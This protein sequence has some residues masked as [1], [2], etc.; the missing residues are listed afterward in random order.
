MNREPTTIDIK[1]KITQIF[2]QISPAQKYSFVNKMNYLEDLDDLDDISMNS[3]KMKGGMEEGEIDEAAGVGIVPVRVVPRVP[4]PIADPEV[5]VV[6]EAEVPEANVESQSSQAFSEISLDEAELEEAIKLQKSNEI[7]RDEELKKFQ[8]EVVENFALPEAQVTYRD[9]EIITELIEYFKEEKSSQIFTNEEKLGLWVSDLMGLIKS[10]SVIEKDKTDETKEYIRGAKEIPDDYKPI[11]ES[12]EKGL[13]TSV[14]WITPLVREKRKIYGAGDL[15]NDYLYSVEADEEIKN[16]YKVIE[17][18]SNAGPQADRFVNYDNQQKILSELNKTSNITEDIQAEF[19]GKETVCIEKAEQDFKQKLETLEEETDE[20]FID[21]E[22]LKK[23]FGDQLEEVKSKCSF[24]YKPMNLLNNTEIYYTVNENNVLSKRVLDQGLTRLENVYKMKE[25]QAA[26]AAAAKVSKKMKSLGTKKLIGQREVSVIEPEKVLVDG[27]VLFPPGFKDSK[28]I[29]SYYTEDRLVVP[30]DYTKTRDEFSS[31][32]PFRNTNDQYIVFDYNIPKNDYLSLKKD[33]NTLLVDKRQIS[34]SN[35]KIDDKIILRFTYPSIFDTANYIPEKIISQGVKQDVLD[36]DNYEIPEN[37]YILA[38]VRD[39]EEPVFNERDKKYYYSDNSVAENKNHRLH[40]TPITNADAFMTDFWLDSS[41]PIMTPNIVYKFPCDCQTLK[42]GD[43]AFIVMTELY[44]KIYLRGQKIQEIKD[45]NRYY[46]GLVDEKQVSFVDTEDDAFEIYIVSRDEYN[47]EF[48]IIDL[49]ETITLSI[50]DFKNIYL[51]KSKI[52][53]TL[54]ENCKESINTER[55]NGEVQFVSKLKKDTLE[56]WGKVLAIYDSPRIS[57]NGNLEKLKSLVYIVQSVSPSENPIGSIFLV[58]ERD[59]KYKMNKVIF[60]RNLLGREENLVNWFKGIFVD[61]SIS[62]FI[63]TLQEFLNKITKILRS[64]DSISFSFIN[65]LLKLALNYEENQINTIVK[66]KLNSWIEWNIIK[67]IES[68]GLLL[69]TIRKDYIDVMVTY[70]ED[71]VLSPDKFRLIKKVPKELMNYKKWKVNNG[72]IDW[73]KVKNRDI[74]SIIE[75]D[76]AINKK[77]W[78]SI[79]KDDL[80]DSQIRNLLIRSTREQV[81]NKIYNPWEKSRLTGEKTREQKLVDSI[82]TIGDPATKSKLLLGFIENNC[83]LAEDFKTKKSWYYS[84]VDPKKTRLLCPHVYTDLLNES[85][86]KYA[87]K[88]DDGVTVCNNCG[89]VLNSLTFSYFEGYGDEALSRGAVIEVDGVERVGTM[90]D[91]ELQVSLEEISSKEAPAVQIVDSMFKADENPNEHQLERLFNSVLVLYPRVRT[92]LGSTEEGLEIKRGAIIDIKDYNFDA[93]TNDFET[94]KAK[95]AKRLEK[96]ILNAIQKDKKARETAA[97]AAK[98]KFEY[99][100]DMASLITQKTLTQIFNYEA[101]QSKFQSCIARLAI[102]IEIQVPKELKEPHSDVIR[103][104]VTQKADELK[105]STKILDYTEKVRNIYLIFKERFVSIKKLYTIKAEGFEEIL[106]VSEEKY[107]NMTSADINEKLSLFDGIEWLKYNLK[108][109]HLGETITIKESPQVDCGLV[110]EETY[111]PDDKLDMTRKLERAIDKIT[112]DK[113]RKATGVKSRKQFYS[114]IEFR[115]PE[116]SSNHIEASFIAKNLFLTPSKEQLKEVESNVAKYRLIDYLVTYKYDG[117]NIIPI[118]YD[119]GVDNE[120]GKSREQLIDDYK[121]LNTATL[122]DMYN[123]LKFKSIQEEPRKILEECELVEINTD[124]IPQVFD[125]IIRNLREVCEVPKEF[126]ALLKN[127]GREY[128]FDVSGEILLE[129]EKAGNMPVKEA[130]AHRRHVLLKEYEKLNKIFSILK[131]DYN[132]LANSYDIKLRITKLKIVLAGTADKLASDE[133]LNNLPTEYDYLIPFTSEENIENRKDLTNLTS[134]LEII[135]TTD[136]DSNQGD[137]LLQELEKRNK[138]NTLV[139]YIVL[140]KILT[141][142]KQNLFAVSND[143]FVDELDNIAFTAEDANETNE[144]LG[145]FLVE[146]VKNLNNHFA[147]Q[148]EVMQGI[149]NYK[150]EVFDLQRQGASKKMAKDIAIIG[151]DLAFEFNKV[152]KGKRKLDIDV[153]EIS[154][155]NPLESAK[156]VRQDR[157]SAEPESEYQNIAINEI[158]GEKEGGDELAEMDKTD[159]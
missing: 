37:I 126:N 34:I 158:Q 1:N 49:E 96:I 77:R 140:L 144:F 132:Y 155:D 41:I 98:K 129:I 95:S 81:I 24:R 72:A 105:I 103:S 143:A 101:E 54:V 26:Q 125:R 44:R 116:V 70:I 111:T 121:T 83:Y 113:F 23:Q 106:G 117:S 109:A 45:K 4:V 25:S 148:S 100:K 141:Q 56:V 38:S 136:C 40:V 66:S 51:S 73:S 5:A 93:D 61:T 115:L 31:V 110:Q 159:D 29:G 43:T 33:T 2:S 89:N 108:V 156:A 76:H 151:K 60:E 21:Y 63:P 91:I 131:R 90:E 8:Y 65:V 47:I 94:W 74:V 18:K 114:D 142:N 46:V 127:I 69:E 86:E 36:L 48:T 11:V 145:N 120:S 62:H 79:N 28:H 9:D 14:E 122:K 123:S 42:G 30:E 67:H 52:S 12:F 135:Q 57:D 6:E 157:Y 22:E 138:K 153:T 82:L 59:V 152:M 154:S 139:L 102:I 133:F 99:T 88:T 20:G 137:K 80:I 149:R 16:I 104:I 118:L 128:K 150:Q 10:S 50:S 124:K 112:R 85:L 64:K 146:F 84:R 107:T 147:R 119:N 75:K 35:V 19:L 13:G 92:Y 7:F 32:I 17:A 87:M 39:V 134:E 15:Q 130:F 68:R 78:N 27:F 71:N 3:I 97:V 53:M 55:T 58:R